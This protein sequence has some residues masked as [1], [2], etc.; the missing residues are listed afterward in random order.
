MAGGEAYAVTATLITKSDGT[1]FGKSEGGNIWLDP[2]KTS[3]FAFYQFWLNIAD[4]DAKRF[5]KIYSLKSREEIETLIAAHEGN[6]FQRNLQRALAEEMTE[7]VHSKSALDLAVKATQV[8]FGN[9]TKEDL[10]SLDE[11]T[12]ESSLHGM[13]KFVVTRSAIEAG[14]SVLDILAVETGIFPSKGEAKKM[15]AANGFSINKEKFSDVDGIIDSGYLIHKRFLIAQ[16]G[17][18]NYFVIE[19]Q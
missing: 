2:N 17:K 19:V 8:F 13:E 12:L 11:S 16:K 9:G 15:I 3:P 7:R 6:E 14:V 5:M 18:K 10:L 4:E 1:K